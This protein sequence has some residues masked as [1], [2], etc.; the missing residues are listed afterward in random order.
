[1][2]YRG[3]A[4]DPFQIQAIE[5]LEAGQ[6]LLVCAPTGTG[7]TALARG[8]RVGRLDPGLD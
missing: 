5:A 3:L 2:E 4:L 8:G 1:M 6:S 7:K